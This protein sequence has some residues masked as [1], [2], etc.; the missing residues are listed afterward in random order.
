MGTFFFQFEF[1]HVVSF[2]EIALLVEN[3]GSF[4]FHSQMLSCL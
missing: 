1:L 4:P 2:A 3:G